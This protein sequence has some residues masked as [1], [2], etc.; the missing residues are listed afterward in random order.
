MCLHVYASG[1]TRY[2]VLLRRQQSKGLEYLGRGMAT[3]R[4]MRILL[5]GCGRW[6]RNILRDLH[7]LGLEV[8]VADPDPTARTYARSVGALQV[9]GDPDEL[10]DC[11]GVVIATP[12]A[13]HAQVIQRALSRQVPVFVEKPMTS[14]AGEA[15]RLA[16]H[17]DGKLFVMDKWRYHPGVEELGRIHETCELGKPLGMHLYHGGWGHPHADVDVSWVLLS[18]CL[19]IFLEIFGVLPDTIHGFAERLEWED[20]GASR[21]ARNRTLGDC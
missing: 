3:I 21:R 7:G 20:R 6:G 2:F 16:E 18:H 15:R 19:S 8:S 9:A 11:E 14:D 10:P 1:S 12:T 4:T 17:A 13:T 5:L